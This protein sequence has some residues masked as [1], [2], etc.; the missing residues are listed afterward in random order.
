MNIY[1]NKEGCP[2]EL[3]LS[4]IGGKWKGILFYH[5]IGGK[6]GLMNFGAFVPAL[7]SVC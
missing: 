4:V 2:V 3:T 5:M 6:S 7:R 1:P